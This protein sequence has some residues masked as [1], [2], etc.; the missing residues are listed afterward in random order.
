MMESE[1]KDIDRLDFLTAMVLFIIF[2]QE[3]FNGTE[4]LGLYLLGFGVIIF[5]ILTFWRFFT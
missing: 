1:R 3:Y 4:G 2:K 5:V